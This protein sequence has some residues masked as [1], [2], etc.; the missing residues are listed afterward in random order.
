MAPQ[1]YADST[2]LYDSFHPDQV[3]AIVV[4]QN[5]Q[6]CCHE[7]KEWMS[8]NRLKLNDGKIEAILCG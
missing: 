8:S 7:I 1:L 4:V 3:A 6:K 2:A 5:L